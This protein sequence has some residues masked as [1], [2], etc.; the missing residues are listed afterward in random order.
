MNQCEGCAKGYES[1]VTLN[2]DVT[3]HL[4]ED[5]TLLACTSAEYAENSVQEF[6]R[7]VVR[8]IVDA[9]AGM[10]DHDEDCQP[11]EDCTHFMHDETVAVVTEMLE[12]FV[13]DGYLLI[14]KN[15]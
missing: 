6:L 1:K 15:S 11:G 5:G 7:P 2:S 8:S 4:S 12:V 13:E 10:L 3:V 9:V 14:G